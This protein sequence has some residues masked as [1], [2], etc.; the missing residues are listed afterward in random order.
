MK[1]VFWGTPSYALDSLNAI[2]DSEHELLA[3]V[4]QPDKRRG[5]GSHK[6]PSPIK[7]RAIELGLKVFTPERIKNQ[8]EIKNQINDIKLL[9]Q[10]F[11]VQRCILYSTLL[12]YAHM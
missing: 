4:T 3:V 9:W 5:R 10:V 1:V 6:S 2:V 8:E 12:H 11:Y 7:K